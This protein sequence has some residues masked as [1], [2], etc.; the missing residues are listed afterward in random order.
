MLKELVAGNILLDESILL[1]VVRIGC[2]L[3]V[4]TTAM[5]IENYPDVFTVGKISMPRGECVLA[6]AKSL[7]P[8]CCSDFC[9]VSDTCFRF[10]VESFAE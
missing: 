1:V 8:E 5:H 4:W 6:V 10:D 7:K 2:E 3:S 9:H